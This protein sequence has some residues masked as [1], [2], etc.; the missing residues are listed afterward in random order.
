MTP[1]TYPATYPASISQRLLWQA[2]FR[3]AAGATGTPRQY[4]IRDLDA[5]ALQ[6]ALSELRSRH[7]ALRTR[8]VGSGP[9]LT[10]E[11]HEPGEFPVE[12]ID[13][14]TDEG[15][16][17]EG[18]GNGTGTGEKGPSPDAPDTQDSPATPATPGRGRPE[19]E[20]LARV[21]RR[22]GVSSLVLDVDHL[23]TDAWSGNV[24][25]AELGHLYAACREGRE[26]EL[27]PV[28]WQYRHFTEWQLGRL[29][30]PALHRLQEAWLT[31]LAG[32]EPVRL[33]QP[34]HR[35][36][37]RERTA[38]LQR[39]QAGEATAGALADL[40]AAGGTTPASAA[41]TMF[42]LQLGLVSGQDDI[43]IGSVFANRANVRS[44]RSVGLFA[45]LVPLRLALGADLT[46]W[47]LLRS[48]HEMMTHALVNQ[49]LPMSL[50]PAGALRRDTAIG[51]NSTVINMMPA[52]TGGAGRPAGENA[53]APVPG[54][55]PTGARFDFELGLLSPSS[56]MDGFIR[57]AADRFT[58]EWVEEF[59]NGLF[60]LIRTGAADVGLTLGQLRKRCL[61]RLE[62]LR[63]AEGR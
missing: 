3:S 63:S 7:E 9:R 53:V 11:I 50:L 4:A 30:G 5:P 61:W 54:R 17:G 13:G 33:P 45:H 52:G 56:R 49:E 40:G 22:P 29:N 20:V 28:G 23:F 44:W 32:A 41:T 2:A 60:D 34:D 58:A 55:M 42:L 19:R 1:A 26:P 15:T 57:Y 10:Q 31:R 38:V 47:E 25:G 14:D 48:G 35:V 24:L 37:R 12:W 39:F 21:W 59:R 8:L 46:L 18:A 27:P 6:R 43:C 36:P 62:K 51:V 16:T